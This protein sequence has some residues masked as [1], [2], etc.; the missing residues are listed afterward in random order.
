MNSHLAFQI[1]KFYELS[2][3][4]YLSRTIR[5]NLVNLNGLVF[6]WINLYQKNNVNIEVNNMINKIIFDLIHI[7]ANNETDI[8]LLDEFSSTI[9]HYIDQQQIN[10]LTFMFSQL[11]L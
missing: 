1:L 6:E 8:K 9:V 4:Y 3:N 7:F 10:E 2:K 5:N 11:K